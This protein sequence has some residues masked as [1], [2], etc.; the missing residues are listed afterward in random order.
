ML[1]DLHSFP[2][3]DYC[4]LGSANGIISLSKTILSELIRK[5]SSCYSVHAHDGLPIG[6]IKFGGDMDSV[7]YELRDDVEQ[8]EQSEIN[9]PVEWESSAQQLF[10]LITNPTHPQWIYKWE[11]TIP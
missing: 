11:P 2:K 9:G 7:S 5:L 8:I 3:S 1:S 10:E 6:W 4:S